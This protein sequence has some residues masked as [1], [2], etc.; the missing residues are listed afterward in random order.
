[1]KKRL[2]RVLGAFTVAGVA[3]LSTAVLP[4]ASPVAAG[5]ADCIPI[6]GGINATVIGTKPVTVM[7][8]VT[9]T[10]AGSTMAVVKSQKSVGN[11][12]IE[13]AV[14]HDFVTE[15]RS[16]IKTCLLYTSPSPRDRTRSR[17]PSSA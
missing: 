3:A 7:G 8:P 5:A 9:G 2:S 13:L 10:L 11:G 15:D 6:S 1:M 17:M 4:G 14:T 12:V 16:S